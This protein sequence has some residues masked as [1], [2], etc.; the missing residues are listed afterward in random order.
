M[1]A[2]LSCR[3]EWIGNG[4]S[5]GCGFD[6]TQTPKAS[7][8]LRQLKRSDCRHGCQLASGWIDRT[9]QQ[10]HPSSALPAT[11]LKPIKL[12]DTRECVGLLAPT[13]EGHYWAHTPPIEAG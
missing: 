12:A 1:L 4:V 5:S 10:S 13:S 6:N 11:A 2:G 8:E 7:Q 9:S 3:G